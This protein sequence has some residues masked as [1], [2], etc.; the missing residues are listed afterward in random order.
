MMIGSVIGI[1]LKDKAVI[2]KPFG[3]VFLNLLFTVVVPLV[4]FSLSSAVAQM[5]DI[6]RLGKIMS[7]M[8]IVFTVT[9]IVASLVM[10][11]G[12]S[13]FPPAQGIQ[14]TL[15]VG[16]HPDQV[17]VTDQIVKAVTVSDFADLWSKKNMLA[18]IIFAILLGVATSLVGQKARAF[19]EFLVSGNE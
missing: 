7:W 16:F 15:P 17:K 19:T 18:L 12:V 2:L 10:I 14:M 5:K 11:V 9:G 6:A 13:W 3:D 1:V 8:M 4:F